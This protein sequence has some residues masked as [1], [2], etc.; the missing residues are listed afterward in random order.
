VHPAAQVVDG[1]DVEGAVP[2]RELVEA[3]GREVLPHAVE[4]AV[5]RQIEQRA[6]QARLGA[7]RLRDDGVGHVAG[8]FAEEP[9]QQHRPDSQGGARQGPAV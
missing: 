6:R 8:T 3:V 5:G 4:H 2:G 9:D 7:G 1:G